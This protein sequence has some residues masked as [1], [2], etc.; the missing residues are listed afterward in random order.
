MEKWHIFT[1]A[2]SDYFHHFSSHTEMPQQSRAAGSGSL[3]WHST[4][5]APMSPSH[6]GAV[7]ALLELSV[8]VFKQNYH[9]LF[10]VKKEKVL[11][12]SHVPV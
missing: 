3:F 2:F 11:T 10:L 4:T 8:V 9:C 7:K 1:L 12:F 5:T 6:R